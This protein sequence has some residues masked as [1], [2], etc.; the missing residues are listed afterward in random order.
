MRG[1]SGAKPLNGIL[2]PCEQRR[3]E[4]NVD[5]RM[6]EVYMSREVAMLVIGP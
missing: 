3:R 1:I 6:V 4:S 5:L 2:P